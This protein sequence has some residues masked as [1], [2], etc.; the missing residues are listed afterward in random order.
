MDA[1]QIRELGRFSLAIFTCGPIRTHVYVLFCPARGEAVL[2]D[3]APGSCDVLGPFLRRLGLSPVALLLTHGHW[4][5]TAQA[6]RF[7]DLSIPVHGSIE[8]LERFRH[9]D[10]SQSYAAQRWEV[11]PCEPDVKLSG[12]ETLSLMGIDWTVIATAGHTP[13]GLVYYLG[14]CALAFTGDSLFYET[15][16][17]S[18]FPYGDGPLLIRHL[19]ERVLCLPDETLC[20]PGHGQLTTVGHERT[21]N[22][23]L[24]SA[25][26]AV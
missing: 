25:A 1:V 17:R 7:Q 13:G 16:G 9:P 22:P 23:F 5:H 15:I 19:L 6:A 18:D 11:L 8:D 20:A 14:D 26:E 3:A 12:G 21:H 24:R 4:D 2:V 10:T